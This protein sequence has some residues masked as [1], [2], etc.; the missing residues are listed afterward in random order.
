M[1]N[2]QTQWIVNNRVAN[3][4]A[5]VTGLGDVVQHGNNNGNYSEWV[6][7]NAAVNFLDDPIT[8]G[9]PQGIPYS[10][11]VGNHDQGPSG[12]GAPDDTAAF[13]Q[14]F[15]T[16][17]YAGKPYYGGHF[18]SNN[19]NHYAL[20]SASGMDFILIN[21]AYMDPQ[22]DGTELNSVLAW[23]NTLLQTYNSRR[24][25]IVSHYL[26]NSG[27][28]ASWS[29]QGLSTYNALKGNPNLFL[30]LA[31]HYTPPEGQRT[32]IYS[33]NTIQS[34]MSDY[35]EQGSGGDGYL[36]IMNFSPANNLISVSTYSPYVN[37]FKTGSSSQFTLPYNMQNSGY[38]VIGTATGVT[39]GSQATSVWNNLL[40]GTQYDWYAVV[41]NGT[42]ST[43]GPTWNFTTAASAGPVV[44]FSSNS[45]TFGSQQINSTSNSQNITLTNVGN[46]VLS[47]TSIV[48]SGDFAQTNT[49]GASVPATGSCQISVTFTPTALGTRTGAITF[50]DNATGSPQTLTLTG[51]GT[52]VAAPAVSLSASTLSFGSPA[53]TVV[54]DAGA[55]GSGSSTLAAKFPGNVTKN[56]LMVVGVS[57][58]AGNA[59]ASPAIT[60]TLGSAWSLAVSRNPGTAGT[61]SL[62]GIYYAIV[63]STGA[64]TVTVHMTGTNNL[65]LHIYEIS[66]LLTSSVLDQIGSNFQSSG[67]AATVS[68]SAASIAANEFVF[69][70]FGRDNG[71][72]TWTAG[73]GF[74]NTLATPNTGAGTDAFSE[75]KIISSTG[76]QTA[77]ASSSVPDSITS[78]IATFQAGA[79]STPVGTTSA[80]QTLTLTNNGNGSLNVSSIAPSGDFGETNTCGTI[81]IAAGSCTISITFTPTATGPRAGAITFVDDAANSPQT[82]ILNGTGAPA[83]GPVVSLTPANLTFGSQAVNTASAVQSVTLTNTGTA[84]L[85]VASIAA[86]APYTQTNT[87]GTSVAA[88]GTCTI[89][90][91]FTP[92]V[93][94]ALPGTITITD[95][96]TGAPHVVNLTGTGTAAN[97]P[98]VSLAPASLAFG[99]QTVNKASA[100]Q[101]VTLTNTGTAALSITSIAAS[102]P[103]TQTNTCGASVAASGTCTISVTFTPTVTGSQSGTVTFTDNA[104]GSPQT[105][106][107]TGTGTTSG[108]TTVSLSPTS[109]I[110]NGQQINT[111]SSSKTVR[112]SNTGTSVLSIISIAPSGDFSETN[113]CGASLAAAARCTITVKFTPLSVGSRTGTITISDNATGNPHTIALTGTGAN[114]GLSPTSLS[115]GTEL[116]NTTSASQIVSMTNSGTVALSITRITASTQ[117]AQTNTCGN[118]L[119][120]GANCTINVTFTPTTAGAHT[121][122]ITITNNATG[123]PR[124]VSLSGTGQ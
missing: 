14:Y 86:S 45:L 37:L 75:D 112:L 109:L 76:I 73:A 61:P 55:T 29:N 82:V 66:G 104:T 79:G 31:G 18:G 117:Y 52:S 2:S 12:D 39:S 60:D 56:N 49:C 70:Y 85:S 98:A 96:A 7:A 99:N 77:T 105:V 6:N 93:I 35:Q 53:V 119:V 17:R 9:L 124:T 114:I 72:G 94:G 38:S 116:L 20:F 78:L 51:T 65:H 74:G 62:A 11:G 43:T 59:F 34:V 100:V 89:S 42:L 64:D 16:A 101:S 13:N 4:I 30:M 103:Y 91:T 25:I 69:A 19:D 88:S 95:N 123:S 113:N 10:F 97:A 24:G 32:D 108:P 92:T 46:A 106:I 36:R 40:P 120:A 57:S 58:Y 47:I 15:G 102:A 33:G 1:F 50:N 90:V 80:A 41:S 121:G 110:F 22:Y 44:I 107:L 27:L 48:P 5:F 28:N 115:F 118:S 3:N 67:T 111:T 54:Q 23:A 71:S 122:T 68:T 87:C 83:S 63:P 21:M 8:T 26:I 84:A 81:V